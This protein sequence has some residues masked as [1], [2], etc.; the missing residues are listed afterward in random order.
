MT[1]LLTEAFNFI[2]IPFVIAVIQWLL[3]AAI[4]G[5]AGLPRWLSFFPFVPIIA[6]VGIY[7]GGG[8]ISFYEVLGPIPFSITLY[9]LVMALISF[10]PLFVVVF[11]R[12]PVTVEK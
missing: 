9:P 4:L 7:F 5:K 12:W 10:I 11:T 1:A 8:W 3:S 6:Q 2:A